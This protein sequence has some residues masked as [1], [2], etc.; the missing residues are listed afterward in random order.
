[1]NASRGVQ[2]KFTV[3]VLHLLVRN[4]V[5]VVLTMNFDAHPGAERNKRPRPRSSRQRVGL[6]TVAPGATSGD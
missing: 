2:G 3:H 4:D 5:L 6:R 1:M